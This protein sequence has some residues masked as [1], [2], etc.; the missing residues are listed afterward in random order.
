MEDVYFTISSESKGF[1]TE[2]GSKFYAYIFPVE[3][4][5][6][7]K[8]ILLDLQ[9]KYYNARHIVYAY[10]TGY[11]QENF[12]VNDAGEPANSAGMPILGQ[13]KS[14]N[15]TN[16]LIVVVR[17]FGGTKLGIQGLNNAY[18]SAATDAIS[19]AQIIKKTINV[20]FQITFDYSEMKFVQRVI[21][22]HNLNVTSQEFA[23]ICILDFTGRKSVE[24]K[25]ENIFKQNPK[26]KF[27]KKC[28]E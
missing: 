15:L 4:E 5:Y 14:N 18:K 28:S 26:I 3:N 11:Y 27:Y 25:I 6:S 24:V 12:R 1:Y 13:I 20:F 7:I 22:E 9:K 17:Y 23:D 21:K 2:K 19:N 8:K 16:V 10:L